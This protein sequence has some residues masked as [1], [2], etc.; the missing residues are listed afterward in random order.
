MFSA[1]AS[2]N[3]KNLLLQSLALG[4]ESLE[5]KYLGLSTYIGRSRT[6]CFT[7]IKENILKRLVARK[8]AAQH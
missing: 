3:T 2:R 8:A 5:G 7:H 1:N 6:K 4:A